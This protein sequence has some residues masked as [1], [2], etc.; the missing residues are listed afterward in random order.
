MPLRG[1]NSNPSPEGDTTTIHDSLFAITYSR[2]DKVTYPLVVIRFSCR[3][4]HPGNSKLSGNVPFHCRGGARPRPS[5][6]A[7]SVASRHLP[8]RGR[9]EANAR[10]GDPKNTA[11]PG[12]SVRPGGVPRGGSPLLGIF[13][14]VG[15][16]RGRNR[17]LP[18]PSV[19]SLW[20]FLFGQAKR[21]NTVSLR[22]HRG[23]T[24]NQDRTARVYRINI[25][26]A[27]RA[28]P[29]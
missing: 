12:G 9:Q 29:L 22:V 14:R 17:N 2:G 28:T 26:P 1:M 19:V 21:K 24:R 13:I 15:L 23:D 27:L 16:G 8:L 4:R 10:R 18:L 6:S 25:P 7:P 20:F 11:P 5:G 3:G